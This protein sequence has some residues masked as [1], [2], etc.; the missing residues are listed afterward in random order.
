MSPWSRAGQETVFD[1]ES[2]VDFAERFVE[3]RVRFEVRKQNIISSVEVALE[4]ACEGYSPS[5]PTHAIFIVH[6]TNR[7][8]LSLSFHLVSR[9]AS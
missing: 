8:Q 5:N 7:V 9:S 3:R 1:A 2:G 6:A 4:C